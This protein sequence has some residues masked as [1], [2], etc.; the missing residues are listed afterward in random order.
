MF[1]NHEKDRFPVSRR[2]VLREGVLAQ[3]VWIQMFRNRC[4]RGIPSALATL[5]MLTS[6][7]LR[8]PRSSK[9]HPICVEA[10]ESRA[11]TEALTANNRGSL[12]QLKEGEPLLVG[13]GEV[14]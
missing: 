4:E 1:A 14:L 12:G 3:L 7:T 10:G 5:S 13:P 11:R 6:A 8:S 2:L 9:T